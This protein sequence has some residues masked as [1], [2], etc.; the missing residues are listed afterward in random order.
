[1]KW[2][3][4]TDSSCDG[5]FKGNS[6]IGYVRVPFTIS[7]ENRDYIDDENLDIRQLLHD[8][9]NSKQAMRSACPSPRAWCQAFKQG[10]IVIA[11]TISA[12]LSGSYNSAIAGRRMCLEK[13]PDKKIFVLDSKSAGTGL[14]LLSRKA[15]DYINNNMEYKLVIDRLS[16]LTEHMHTVFALSSF[17]NLIRNGRI[18]HLQGVM[19]GRLGIWGIGVGDRQGRIA[20]AAKVRGT[21][22][23]LMHIVK[24]IKVHGSAV[25]MVVIS[26]CD[27]EETARELK[28]FLKEQFPELEI[29]TDETGGLCSSYAERGGIIVA[30]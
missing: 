22:R 17:T 21:R 14:G 28:Y 26:H 20:M 9:E 5:G 16:E 25:N 2:I 27:N 18:S 12:Y 6:Q 7:V 30:Y 8:M 1:M 15:A 13:Y 23:M 29:F 24:D 11:I 4:V 3:I 10:D 19:A